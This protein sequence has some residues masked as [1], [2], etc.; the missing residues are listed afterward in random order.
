MDV[1]SGPV[2]FGYGASATVMNIKTQASRGNPKAKSTF[3]AM[4]LL[5]LPIHL[6]NKKYYLLKK[7]PMYDLFM[8][9]GLVEL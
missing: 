9:W 8:L 5:G 7:E 4:N 6:F 3:A 1:D 2:V